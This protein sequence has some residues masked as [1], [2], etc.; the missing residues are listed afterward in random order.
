M[1]VNAQPGRTRLRDATQLMSTSA[2]VQS[3]LLLSG[4][5]GLHIPTAYTY[6][7]LTHTA[8][9]GRST[10]PNGDVMVHAGDFR[11]E[12]EAAEARPFGEFFRGLPLRYKVAITGN[13]AALASYEEMPG[14]NSVQALT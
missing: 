13:R 14:R 10:S 5:H 3:I 7:R 6:P 4:T 2:S 1:I 12:G 11:S 8:C 9:T